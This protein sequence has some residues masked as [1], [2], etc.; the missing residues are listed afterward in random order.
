MSDE[1]MA[2]KLSR[3][4]SLVHIEFPPDVA[5]QIF[6]LN[7]MD[8]Y[9]EP[10]LDGKCVV[11]DN[12]IHLATGSYIAGHWESGGFATARLNDESGRVTLDITRWAMPEVLEN[13]SGNYALSKTTAE[14]EDVSD[15]EVIRMWIFLPS[16]NNQRAFK[17]TCGK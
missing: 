15:G 17:H 3:T 7:T 6:W 5:K 13:T 16:K 12:A 9:M 2:V 8:W 10:W 1:S 11:H 4:D 14:L